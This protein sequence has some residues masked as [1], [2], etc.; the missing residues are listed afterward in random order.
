MAAACSIKHVPSA[1]LLACGKKENS[2]IT[3][4][5]TKKYLCIQ[6]FKPFRLHLVNEL[7]EGGWWIYVNHMVQLKLVYHTEMST[8]FSAA[9]LK[10]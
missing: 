6:L 8:L 9:V 1:F 2:A 3:A 5:F 4:L 7:L 10:C